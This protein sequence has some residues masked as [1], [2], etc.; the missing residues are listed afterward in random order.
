MATRRRLIIVGVL[1]LVAGLIMLFPARVAFNWFAPPEIRVS[2]I[3][4][5]IWSGTASHA[6]G[7]GLYVS[8]LQWR[9]QPLRL[10]T[11][12]LAYAV[13]GS[14]GAGSLEADLAFGIGGDIYLTNMSAFVPL[15]S[16]EAA[17]GVRGIGGTASAEFERLVFSNG[18]P[19]SAQG[20]IEVSDL[21]L[22]LVSQ[23]SIGGYSAKFLTQE[24]GVVASVDDTDG[25]VDIIDGRLKLASDRNYEFFGRLATKPETPPQMRQ[26]M[27]F[28]GSPNDLGQYELR[29]EGQL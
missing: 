15:Q 7:G 2:G 8:N 10:F 17:S 13:S 14:P 21:V 1:T 26:Q 19:V 23:T 27:Q 18:L 24:D 11:A 25:V 9:I 6:T 5:T 28:L 20:S 22:P 3:S 16:L 12:K 4:G 29:L